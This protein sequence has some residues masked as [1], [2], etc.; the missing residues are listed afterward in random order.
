V[1]NGFKES[2]LYVRILSYTG[3]M[4]SRSSTAGFCPMSDKMPG[5]CPVW[6]TKCQVSVLR[7]NGCQD[8]VL[9][10]L[11]CK[12]SVLHVKRVYVV[13]P[14]GDRM[15]GCLSDKMTEVCP[16]WVTRSHQVSV[17]KAKRVHG[18]YPAGEKGARSQSCR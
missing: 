3:E 11:G 9:Q 7:V 1:K 15:P 6:V 13:S 18:V 16:V 5:V 2:V 8:P 17:L 12:D 14:T 4:G 10:V